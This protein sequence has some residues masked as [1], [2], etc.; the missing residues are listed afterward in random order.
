MEDSENNM[1]RVY[2]HSP[3]LLSIVGEMVPLL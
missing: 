2:T 1:V 3:L